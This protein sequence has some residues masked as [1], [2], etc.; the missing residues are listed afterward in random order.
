MGDQSTENKPAEDSWGA[1]PA[2]NNSGGDF[3]EHLLLQTAPTTVAVTLGEHPLQT[4]P[5]TT[6]EVEMPG[7]EVRGTMRLH[8]TTRE[9]T[10]RTTEETMVKTTTLAEEEA[11]LIGLGVTGLEPNRLRMSHQRQGLLP[12]FSSL[13]T[14][15]RSRS[16]IS[17]PTPTRRY[18]L[19]SHLKT[20]DFTHSCSRVSTR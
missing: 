6:V 5:T 11:D 2:A 7:V 14:R 20:L 12:N 15:S 17:K 18:T 16:G 1:P 8:P 9:T 3:G 19:Q 13:V 4:V 10:T